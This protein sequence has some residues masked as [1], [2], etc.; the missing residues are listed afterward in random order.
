MDEVLP[1]GWRKKVEDAF[2]EGNKWPLYKHVTGRDVN[3]NPRY[4]QHYF[5][6]HP[7]SGFYWKYPIHEVL[8]HE[9]NLI[10]DRKVIDL[11]VDH[12]KDES[13]SRKSYLDLL[14]RAVQEE[15][16]DWRMN[17]Y[18]NREYFY[19]FEW[20]KVLQ[21]ASR[22][23]QLMGGWDIERACTYMWASEAAHNLLMPSLAEDWARKATEA[24]QSFYEAWHWRAHIAHLHG[25]WEECL[26]FSRKR[27]T[28]E[29]QSHHLVKPEVWEW[30][31]FDLI[32]LSSHK[33][34]IHE[35]AVN[36]GYKALR[37][38]PNNERLSKNYIFYFMGYERE[39]TSPS[40]LCSIITWAL[41]AK[42]AEDT[43]PLYLHCL[44]MQSYPKN[45]IHLYIRTNDN[46][47][48]TSE[49]LKKF[50]EQFGDSFRS[51]EFDDS[52]IDS[53]LKEYDLHEWNSRRFDVMG[54]IR[55]ESLKYAEAIGSDFYFCSDVDNFLKSNT[56]ASLIFE[57][58][59]VIAPL[60]RCVVPKKWKPTLLENNNFSN[61][62]DEVDMNYWYKPTD[63]YYKILKEEIRGVF[64]VPLIHCSYLI[65]SDV[66]KKINYNYL[67]GDWEYKN[68]SRSC[69][70]NG[71]PQFIDARET[72]GF[73]TLSND[74]DGCESAL[75]SLK[76]SPTRGNIFDDI[77]TNSKWGE[78]SGPGSDPDYAKL[79]IDTVNNY[80]SLPQ[81]KSILDIGF[82]DW[83]LGKNYNL[84][85]KS[86]IGLEVSNAAMGISEKYERPNVKFIFG[87]AVDFNFEL[88][89][90]ILIKDVLQHLSSENIKIIL[91]KI[92]NSGQLALICND[93]TESNS[94]IA[95][96]SWRALNL[97]AD[98]F[99]YNLKELS[100]FG[101]EGQ[102]RKVINLFVSDGWSGGLPI[103]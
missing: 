16:N 20:L 28:L 57:S 34:D 86:Y 6:I 77:Y 15:P 83:R 33:L 61:F 8:V 74:I 19:N 89:D 95:D 102:L 59:P 71:I 88:V 36:F 14:E 35:D 54:K 17:H 38:C 99:N 21:S 70:K 98:P 100:S 11:E 2:D 46:K 49:V 13:K 18:L 81:I 24:S 41:L 30:W 40:A 68:F 52:S 9:P 3:G 85:G 96:G 47:D 12:I 22:C 5:K 101:K 84:E 7:R 26:E 80:L 87:D 42:D 45:L 10:F 63:R 4:F 72:Y 97:N 55:Q 50:I 25:K 39:I 23:E 66:F 69:A 29:R 43:L 103:L 94:D 65:R 76:S 78:M 58:K 1:P 79:W 90:L 53:T 93:F 51:I 60:L 32:A 31:G 75:E 92:F 27:L 73:L 48:N 82:G 56:L 44:L 64:E 62:H 37:N 91:E 67:E